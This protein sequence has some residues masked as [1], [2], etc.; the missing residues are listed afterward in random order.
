M[1]IVN[2]S[3]PK[4]LERKISQAIEDCGL[5]SKAEFFRFAAIRYIEEKNKLPLSDNLRLG[6]LTAALE[7]SLIAKIQKNKL[8]SIKKQLNMLAD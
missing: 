8:P 7:E 3:I 5:A 2:F 1:T 6:Y 4:T